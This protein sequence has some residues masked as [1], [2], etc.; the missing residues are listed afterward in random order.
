[1]N[2]RERIIAALNHRKSDV[3]PIDFGA[4]RST[5]I[6][7]WAYQKLKEHLGMDTSTSKLYDVFQQLA[8][9]EKEILDRLGAD[10]VQV[11]RLA[12]SFGVKIDRWKAG[13][14]GR[15]IKCMVPEDYHPIPMENGELT[16]QKDGKVLAK[17]P[18]E[19]YY[20]D[21]T[22]HPLAE[23]EDAEDLENYTFPVI[24][25]EEICYMEQ[26]AKEAYENTDRAVLMEFGGNILE[27]GESDFGFENFFMNLLSEPE[28][29]HTYLERLTD[30]YIESLKRLMPRVHKYIQIIQFGDDLGSQESTLISKEVYREM[31]KP[32]HKKVFHYIRDNY[33]EVK[34]FLHSCGAILE[35]IPD[36]IDAGVQILNPIQIAAKGMDPETLVERFGDDLVFWGGGS[37]TQVTCNYG[38]VDEIQTEVK[39]LI[40]IFSKKNG[41]V[42]NQVHNLQANVPPEKILAIYDAA[43][44]Y[45][46]EQVQSDKN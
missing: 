3:I 32:Y 33:P 16:I 29:V 19:G 35:L 9:P 13:D 30:S 4:M 41:Y 8:E 11:H 40:Q 31:I 42:F 2:S 44:E 15:G 7:I 43:Q 36:L 23:A 6:S 46:K 14:N 10:V 17:M 39:K 34:V 21:Q 25:E 24:T 38:T 37:N 12:A 26:Q 5:G 22:C 20:F 1:M 18:R 27:A 28:L 45:R